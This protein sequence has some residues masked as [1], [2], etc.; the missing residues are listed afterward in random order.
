MTVIARFEILPVGES[1]MSESIA[2]ALDALEETGV[3]Y[4]TTGMDTIVEAETA[5]EVFAALQAAHEAA[6]DGRLVTNIEIDDD[7][8][9]EQSAKDRVSAV[10]KARKHSAG[11]AKP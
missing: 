10:E 11:A 8:E 6:A 7:P 9:A 5:G 2:R 1:H 4:E 3:T